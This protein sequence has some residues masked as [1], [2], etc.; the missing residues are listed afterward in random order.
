[1]KSTHIKKIG[2]IDGMGAFAGSRFFQILL[3]KIT[4]NRLAFPEIILDAVAVDD[5]ISD[6]SR[7]PGA[8]RT[9]S[10]RVK[11]FNRLRVS[12]VV[13]ACNTA[14]IL[15]PRLQKI[16]VADFPSIISLVCHQ[17]GNLQLRRVGILA[18][19]MTIHHRLYQSGLESSN[20]QPFVPDRQ[21]QDFIE[22]I[23]RRV[24]DHNQT[25]EDS[26]IFSCLSRKFINRH[27]LD[28]LILGCTELPLVFPKSEFTD[29]SVIDS[30]DVLADSVINH[31]KC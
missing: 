12:N 14:H 11:Q 29:I 27:K 2:I 22:K 31:L 13:M 8:F 15:H 30:L 17:A 6:P 16:S 4:T 25:M 21:F 28:G 20:I 3:E 10:A 24:I 7:L 26:R 9:I 23:I 18:S 1:M 5:F 19:P